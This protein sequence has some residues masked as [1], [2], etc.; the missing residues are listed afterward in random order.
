MLSSTS[1]AEQQL[2]EYRK[3]VGLRGALELVKDA[4][5]TGESKFARATSRRL[6]RMVACRSYAS[7]I[8]ELTHLVLVAEAC[9]PRPRSYEALFWG[10]GPAKAA[11]FRAFIT[12][13]SKGPSRRSDAISVEGKA[14]TCIYPDGQFT[15]SFSRM[16]LLSALM[17]F[18]VTVIGYCEL[19]DHLQ[20]IFENGRS[21]KSVSRSANA[22]AKDLYDY[23]NKEMGSLHEQRKFHK[24]TTFLMSREGGDF[25]ADS[26][27][28]DVIL[29]FWLGQPVE[30]P[31]NLD[32]RTFR[33]VFRAFLNLREA[34]QAA[35]E[36]DGLLDPRPIGSDRMQGEIGP[37][38]L[39]EKLDAIDERVK[40]LDL[41][42]EE[43]ARQI[44]FLTNIERT[45]L[46]ALL[47][48]GTSLP[49]YVL[50][51]MRSQV[52]GDAQARITQDLRMK[53]DA[54]ERPKDFSP[55]I[56]ETY[57][58]KWQDYETLHNK[59]EKT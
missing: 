47:D 45:G 16:P 58:S 48:C 44:K 35:L 1:S 41:L 10:S 3:S 11:S 26:I 13:R 20:A 38:Q 19:D 57:D 28:D 29:D 14:V 22:I 6:A 51:L 4:S 8:L 39:S 42:D 12:D 7:A 2:L 24:L 34:L 49:F 5:V 33:S 18:L 55:F 54:R 31:G 56:Q 46:E 9:A 50:S 21:M 30:E 53:S 23:L 27:T 32:F 43:P 59:L 17:E 37:D 36:A 40:P 52:F 15:I 25:S